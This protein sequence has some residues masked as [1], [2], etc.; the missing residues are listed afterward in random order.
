MRK[1]IGSKAHTHHEHPAI[2]HLLFIILM[3]L[4]L[5]LLMVAGVESQMGMPMGG[6]MHL[7]RPYLSWTSIDV[8]GKPAVDK[9]M[10]DW[11]RNIYMV[12]CATCHGVTG[13]GDGRWAHMVFPKPRNFTRGIF[14]FKST[15]SGTLPTDEDLFRT[16]SVGLNGTAMPPWQLNLT[17][18][19]RWAVVE[20][21]KLFS[22]YFDEEEPGA[23][24]VLGKVPMITQERLASGK[25]IFKKNCVEC[26]GPE[27]F[28][29]GPSA[30]G[31][32]DSFGQPIKPRNFHN[33]MQFKRGHTLTDIALPVITGNDGTPMPAFEGG[34][35]REQV[36]NVAAYVRSLGGTPPQ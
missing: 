36:W 30:K 32:E 26:H 7:R 19:Q 23:P 13:K 20:Y 6:G 4:L 14:R 25:E 34:L 18:E 17:E 24:V 3:I 35:T 9:A 33:V 16:V 10:V 8:G 27:G 31:M 2:K 21:I 28:G 29:D 15:P 12:N 5:I 22:P 1:A 11:G